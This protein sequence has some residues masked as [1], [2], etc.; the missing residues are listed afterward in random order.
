[1]YEII[2]MEAQNA[3]KKGVQYTFEHVYSSIVML[4]RVA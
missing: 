2:L 1:M 4:Y 3:G